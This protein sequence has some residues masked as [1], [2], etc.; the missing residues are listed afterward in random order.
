MPSSPCVAVVDFSSN[1]RTCVTTLKEPTDEKGYNF[2]LI[3]G[4]FFAR[5]NKDRVVVTTYGT[6]HAGEYRHT[7]GI[8]WQLVAEGNGQSIEDEA[9]DL[10]VRVKEGLDERPV[11]VAKNKQTSR[12]IWD[13][14]PQ[15]ERVELGRA[16]IYKWKDKEGLAWEGG[17]YEPAGYQP[18]RRY[19]LVIQTHGFQGSEFR[20]SGL[21][22]TGF[23]ARSL[24]AAGILVLQVG[25]G[26]NCS[27]QTPAEGPCPV[28]A[29]ESA[30]TQ[31]V[32]REK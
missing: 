21:F 27:I 6:Y 10:D 14:N 12:V 17:L 22:P 28:A 1:T 5:G 15:L 4:T 11:L 25:E 31:L 30:V 32:S 29:Y 2:L 16:S 7:S 26:Q 18:G 8:T 9:K 24:A 19:P 20:P 23:A 3:A 13:P